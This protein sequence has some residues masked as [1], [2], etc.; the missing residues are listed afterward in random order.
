MRKRETEVKKDDE[1]KNFYNPQNFDGDW[2]NHVYYFNTN[3][4]NQLHTDYE[5]LHE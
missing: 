1:G 4:G 5:K 2:N 3:F